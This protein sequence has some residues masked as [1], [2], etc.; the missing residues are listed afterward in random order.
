MRRRVRRAARRRPRR[1]EHV[2]RRGHDLLVGDRRHRCALHG[3][4]DA[5]RRS[6]PPGSSRRG[7]RVRRGEPCDRSARR[8]RRSAAVARCAGSGPRVA[9][10]A[11][12]GVGAAREAVALVE[13]HRLPRAEGASSTTSLGEVLAAAG[14]IEE[15]VAAVERAI[16]APRAEGQRR[17]GRALPL[18]AGRASR[19]ATLVDSRHGGVP[20]LRARE[21][22]RARASA[23]S[24]A[25]PL[26]AGAGT[27][28]AQGR[29]RPL[30]RP[31]RFDGARRVDR[32]RGAACADAPVLRGSPRDPRASRRH[33]REVRRRRG[34][35]RLRDSRLARGRCAACGARRVGDARGHRR[36]R[37]RG[38]HR[39][40]HRRG[41]RR[42]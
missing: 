10:S 17:L 29:H 31:R 25:A 21:P 41:R 28:A 3:R 12:R 40:Q 2:L 35:G 7:A 34:H 42:R 38:A 32:S 15:A 30:L 18:G 6:P 26:V 5:R 36:A 22:G 13:P 4:R 39:H 16:D 19:H 37:A 8:P 33:R 24:C 11:R 23:V 27:R 20:E 1:A 14:R 9:G